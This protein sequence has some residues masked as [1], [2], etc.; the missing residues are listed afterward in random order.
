MR[1]SRARKLD[2]LEMVAAV[3]PRGD[4]AHAE[5]LP[6]RA[7]AR[8]PIHHRATVFGKCEDR[9]RD[10]AIC[11]QR[12][13]IEKNPRFP[14]KRGSDIKNALVLQSTVLEEEIISAFVKEQL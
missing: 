1:P 6:I 4:V 3:L 12:V 7:A 2:P 8:R 13:W 5:F 10:R 14:Q 9:Q 11:R